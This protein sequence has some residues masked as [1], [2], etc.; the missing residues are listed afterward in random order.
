MKARKNGATRTVRT[1]LLTATIPTLICTLGVPTAHAGTK[2]TL[3]TLKGKYV[4]SATGFNRLVTIANPDPPLPTTVLQ[5]ST[6]SFQPILR[7]G[8]PG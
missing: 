1:L 2:C 7:P 3:Q 5:R 8:S 4:F 6:I